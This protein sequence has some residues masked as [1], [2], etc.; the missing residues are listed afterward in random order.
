MYIKTGIVLIIAIVYAIIRY[1]FFGPVEAA[2]IPSYLVNKGSSLAAVVYL[3]FSAYARYKNN[4]VEARLWGKTS[5]AFMVFHIFLSWSLWSPGYYEGFYAN[6]D[7]TALTPMMNLKGEIAL[8]SGAVGALV[9][10]MISSRKPKAITLLMTIATAMVCI[11]VGVMGLGGWLKPKSWNGGLPPITLVSF[12]VA[13][14]C[15]FFL[16]IRQP[17]NK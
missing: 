6:A 15:F 12:L 10:F 14:P 7:W 2:N 8:L 1:H 9:Y 11:H 5:L 17:G 4:I 13:L 16:L 3:L